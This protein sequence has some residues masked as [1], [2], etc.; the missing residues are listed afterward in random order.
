MVTR[1]PPGSSA[2][3]SSGGTG[4]AFEERSANVPGAAAGA[5]SLLQRRRALLRRRI[6]RLSTRIVAILGEHFEA[7]STDWPS[8]NQW[9]GVRLWYD[10]GRRLAALLG[11]PFPSWLRTVRSAAS[12][13]PGPTSFQQFTIYEETLLPEGVSSTRR[14]TAVAEGAT[15]SKGVATAASSHVL[16]E[17]RYPR[18]STLQL[19]PFHTPSS[20]SLSI[21]ESS[22]AV[23]VV[24]D[25]AAQTE[26]IPATTVFKE[27]PNLLMEHGVAKSQYSISERDRIPEWRAAINRRQSLAVATQTEEKGSIATVWSEHSA[28]RNWESAQIQL[29]TGNARHNKPYSAGRLSSDLAIFP[30][31]GYV[32]YRVEHDIMWSAQR[33]ALGS[34]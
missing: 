21:S 8:E 12:V 22:T 27:A 5:T 3:P 6:R 32:S 1:Q 4:E 23:L 11:R 19:E 31:W 10:L 9:P 25:R 7:C 17:Q 13:A 28:A 26:T 34:A 14:S 29:P 20:G 2:F 16:A 24:T 15:V 30:N 18:S 33:S